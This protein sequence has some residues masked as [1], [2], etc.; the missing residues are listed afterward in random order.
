MKPWQDNSAD[1][2]DRIHA[3]E[4]ADTSGELTGRDWYYVAADMLREAHDVIMS[5]RHTGAP[6]PSAG[7]AQP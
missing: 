2:I 5:L 4:E 1:I 3:W 7:G 6:E